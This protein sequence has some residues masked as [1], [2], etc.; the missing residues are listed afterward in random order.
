MT[1]RKSFGLGLIFWFFTGGFG[2]HRIYVQEN[3]TIVLWYWLVS[4]VTFGIF[5][6]VDLFLLKG[7]VDKANSK[8]DVVN[9]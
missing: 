5:P 7:L 3:M 2:G 1:E 9:K 4:I 6:I 8:F